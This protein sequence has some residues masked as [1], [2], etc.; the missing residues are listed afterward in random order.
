SATRR[1]S[2]ENRGAPGCAGCNPCSGLW[3]KSAERAGGGTQNSDAGPHAS[4]TGRRPCEHPGR[5]ARGSNGTLRP[6]PAGEGCAAACFKERFASGPRGGHSR[7][8]RRATRSSRS[9]AAS[10]CFTV[11]GRPTACDR[12]LIAAAVPHGHHLGRRAASGCKNDGRQTR[13]GGDGSRFGRARGTGNRA[14]GGGVDATAVRVRRRSTGAEEAAFR[15]LQR[16]G[17]AGGAGFA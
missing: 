9:G 5:C 2:T 14:G 4:S 10:S 8:A 17:S 6:S 7:I 1:G 16:E 3:G 13:S 12:N 15:R 11:S